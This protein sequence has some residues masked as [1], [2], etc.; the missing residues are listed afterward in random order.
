MWRVADADTMAAPIL[1]PDQVLRVRV[2]PVFGQSCMLA[3][4]IEPDQVSQV[5]ISPESGQNCMSTMY[6]PSQSMLPCGCT[7]KS[8][9]S[10]ACNGTLIST[11]RQ[12]QKGHSTGGLVK[13]HATCRRRKGR[14][15]KLC[16]RLH[17]CAEGALRPHHK[18]TE[19]CIK[20]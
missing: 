20:L 19:V 9:A 18:A 16:G 7:I 13:S 2:P 3:L 1:A 17:A 14:L 8:T 11:C 5:R 6:T 4:N 10:P 12:S 15:W